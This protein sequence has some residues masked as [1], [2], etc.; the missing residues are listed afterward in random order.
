MLPRLQQL[1]AEALYFQFVHLAQYL[2]NALRNFIQIWQKCL[3][4]LKDELFKFG[5]QSSKVKVTVTQ[6]FML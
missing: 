3:P 6:E 2:W 1:C 4:G 5:S